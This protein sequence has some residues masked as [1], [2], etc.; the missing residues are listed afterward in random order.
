M[1]DITA[2]EKFG[3]LHV[4]FNNAGVAKFSSSADITEDVI[5]ANLNINAR[6]LAWCFKYQVSHNTT[7]S[8]LPSNDEQMA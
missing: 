4:A 8:L 1:V 7:K 2:V 5:D 6:S 3:A